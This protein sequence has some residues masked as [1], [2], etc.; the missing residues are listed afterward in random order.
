MDH[1]PR[2]PPSPLSTFAKTDSLARWPIDSYTMP[3]FF[4]LRFA[5]LK[6]Y[7]RDDAVRRQI[8][9]FILI[10]NWRFLYA[11]DYVLI[12]CVVSGQ[13]DVGFAASMSDGNYLGSSGWRRLCGCD[14]A[15][16]GILPLNR[17]ESLVFGET[18]GE[19]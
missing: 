9:F 16:G 6:S 11:H 17:G 13:A 3:K 15:V 2:L 4:S 19:F 12:R 10:R 7:E 1:V 18:E 14:S 8:R 5:L